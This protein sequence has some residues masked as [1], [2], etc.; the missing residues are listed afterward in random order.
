MMGSISER[1]TSSSSTSSSSN[2]REID[3]LLRD[4]SEKR[5]N[6]K[7]NVVSLAAELKEVR[8]RLAVKEQSYA[9]ETLTRQACVFLFL[10][11]WISISLILYFVHGNLTLNWN[12]FTPFCFFLFFV[13]FGYFC[14]VG[15]FW[16]GYDFQ[17]NGFCVQRVYCILY[18]EWINFMWFGV[19]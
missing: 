5:Q 13:E 14:F 16:V 6:F 18:Y 1:P 10:L 15:S 17:F 2:G 7:R 19:I 8:T 9:K 11:I 12:H 4:L 3:P